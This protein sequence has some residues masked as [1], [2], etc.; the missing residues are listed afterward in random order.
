MEHSTTTTRRGSAALALLLATA[1]AS[2]C[3]TPLHYL[4]DNCAAAVYECDLA[5][6]I[7]NACSS[8]PMSCS[9][10]GVTCGG[11]VEGDY[12]PV[13]EEA[14]ESSPTAVVPRVAAGPPP[15]TYQPPM[16]PQFLPVPT[17]SVFAKTNS[18]AASSGRGTVEV[19]FSPQRT[20][21]GQD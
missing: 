7:K 5:R 20:F 2:G 17:R 6:L 21:P 12:V 10:S 1:L 16:P 3:G 8:E 15:V 11:G 14:Y 4:P 13:L 9:A 18:L 19:G